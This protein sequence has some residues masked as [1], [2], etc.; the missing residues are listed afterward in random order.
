MARRHAA[1]DGRA[2]RSAVINMSLDSG[3]NDATD[4][5]I[6]ADAHV[7]DATGNTNLDGMLLPQ[8]LSPS[9]SGQS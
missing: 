1:E 3:L 5:A 7:V 6:L 2:F 9:A 8:R 4:G